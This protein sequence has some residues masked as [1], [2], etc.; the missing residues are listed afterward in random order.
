MA[1][2]T[3]V[4][5]KKF[6]EGLKKAYDEAVNKMAQEFTYDGHEFNTGYAKYFLEFYAP[7]FNVKI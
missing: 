5:N 6:I 7:K 1:D 4:I 3:I 2:E